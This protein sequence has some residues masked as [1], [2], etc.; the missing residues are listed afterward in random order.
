MTISCLDFPVEGGNKGVEHPVKDPSGLYHSARISVTVGSPLSR[1]ISET[2]RRALASLVVLQ[3][4]LIVRFHP[5]DQVV[6]P[7]SAGLIR[8]NP[9]RISCTESSS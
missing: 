8:G 7:G 5:G 4:S 3:I 6:Q 2:M 1:A 9:V